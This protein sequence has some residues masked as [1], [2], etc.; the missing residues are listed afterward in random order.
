MDHKWILFCPQLPATPSSPRVMIWRR[1]HAAGSVGL[2]NGLW[3]LPFSEKAALFIGEM[4]EYVLVQG[5]TCKTFL[6]NT[7]DKETESDIQARFLHDRA[8]EYYEIKEQCQDFLAEIAKETKNKNFSFAEYEE[9]E[10]DLEKLENWFVRIQARDFSG[11]APSVDTLEC[12]ERCRQSLQ[13]FADEV[14]THENSTLLK[15]PKSTEELE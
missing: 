9:N 6:T 12:L 8:E 2:D 10:Q 4:K 14:F 5:G 11:G 15:P 7:F 13:T 3:I 1:M